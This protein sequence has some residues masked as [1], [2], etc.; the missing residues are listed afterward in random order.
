LV[1]ARYNEDLFW[2]NWLPFRPR[3]IVY[4]KG[5][6]IKP[7]DDIAPNAG[8]TVIPLPNVGRESHT[9]LHHIV[10]NYDQLADVTIFVQGQIE[11]LGAN[12]FPSLAYYVAP[13][14]RD[15]FSASD[16]ELF[17]PYLPSDAN[18]HGK[19]MRD[20]RYR[21]GIASGDILAAEKDIK[22]FAAQYLGKVPPVMVVS[23]SGCFAVS[24]DTVL[25]RPR[26]F[27]EALLAELAAHKNPEIGHYMERLWCAIFSGNRR[28]GKAI[29][30][31][32]RRIWRQITKKGLIEKTPATRGA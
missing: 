23:F 26:E 27:Y 9:Y 21:A 17:F 14:M 24:R 6:A 20:P 1:V 19:L 4:N 16:L 18:I 30:H 5:V 2:L 25:R 13:A 32:P 22:G 11:D 3:V 7:L 10:A 28:F 31:I 8:G 29:S 12:I 15:G